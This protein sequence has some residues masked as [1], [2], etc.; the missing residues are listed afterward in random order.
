M[1]FLCEQL[2]L[3]DEVLYNMIYLC[4]QL[5]LQDKVLSFQHKLSCEPKVLLGGFV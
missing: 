2:I 5:F 1:I 3:N 4:E